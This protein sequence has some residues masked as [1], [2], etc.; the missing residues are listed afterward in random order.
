MTGNTND[1]ADESNLKPS[2]TQEESADTK[3]PSVDD[4]AK[5]NASDSE[6]EG[7]DKVPFP[8]VLHEIVCDPS[9]DH[10][11]HW[12]P[13]GNFFTIA[14]KKKFAKEVM[15]KLNGHAKVSLL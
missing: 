14:D 15:P 2:A 12:L 9:T 10:C 5:D 3:K 4:H 1:S 11:I 6:D 7:H 8:V 13:D